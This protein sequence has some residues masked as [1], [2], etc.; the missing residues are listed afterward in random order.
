MG[1]EYG[2]GGLKKWNKT[3]VSEKHTVVREG[4]KDIFCILEKS[5]IEEEVD[6]GL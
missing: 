3:Y 4:L 1:E 6:Q 5:A 2:A